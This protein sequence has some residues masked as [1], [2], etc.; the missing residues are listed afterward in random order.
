MELRRRLAS[1]PPRHAERRQL[2][3]DTA[4]LYGVSEA[5]LYRAL[6]DRPRPRAVHRADQGT[7]RVIPPDEMQRYCEVIAAIK[8][9]TSNKQGRHLST[10]EAI[11]L[12]EAFGI[13]TPDGHVHAPQ[14]I[15]TK[16]TVNR[17]LK[18]WGYD[19]ETLLRPPPAVRFQAEYSNE[20][21]HFDLS[22]SDLKQVKSPAWFQAGR[23]HPLLMLYSVVDDRSGV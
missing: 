9:R 21:W 20:C 17:Y 22:P 23:G 11:R 4:T 1:W 13:D 12:L 2:M 18:R 15:L 8:L 14:G 16:P 6:R 10:A 7:P 5:T 3:Q 19:R